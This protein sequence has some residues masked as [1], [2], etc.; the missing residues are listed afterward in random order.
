MK[1]KNNFQKTEKYSL[2]FIYLLSIFSA[3]PVQADGSV[4]SK[5]YHP[6]VQPLET[7]VELQ[8]IY[9]K[10]DDLKAIPISSFRVIFMPAT[11]RTVSE[12]RGLSAMATL[13]FISI[14][15]T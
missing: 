15:I 11:L 3:L 14:C 5:V 12:S 10:D 4:V 1:V 7:E 6:Y 8:T 13:S 2:I 9:E